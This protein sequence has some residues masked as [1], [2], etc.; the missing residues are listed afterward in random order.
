MCYRVPW[1]LFV[2]KLHWLCDILQNNTQGKVI[3]YEITRPNLKVTFKHMCPLFHWC[4][5]QFR[6]KYKPFGLNCVHTH[7]LL[8]DWP[9][10]WG[11]AGAEL[12]SFTSDYILC[13]SLL[14]CKEMNVFL[15]SVYKK[16]KCNFSKLKSS[17]SRRN[18]IRVAPFIQES[19][20]QQ[21]D[22]GHK[23]F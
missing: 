6:N 11:Q 16:K 19:A 14:L 3:F 2:L 17:Y 5:P 1:V 7:P 9:F 15:T 4:S 22:Y 21:K 18:F 13:S 12:C 8:S 20:L 23:A 10:D